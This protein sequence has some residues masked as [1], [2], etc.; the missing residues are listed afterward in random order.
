MNTI[1][2]LTKAISYSDCGLKEI[3]D[4]IPGDPKCHCG[5][6]VKVTA[7]GSQVID[8]VLSSSP[9]HSGR[10]FSMDLLSSWMN[11]EDILGN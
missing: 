1:P 2:S 7:Y 11:W 3:P 10:S 9:T 6:P 8:G 4:L 5:L